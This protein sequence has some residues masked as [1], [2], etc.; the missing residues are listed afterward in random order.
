LGAE[1][2]V[3]ATSALAC[4]GVFGLN[5]RVGNLVHSLSSDDAAERGICFAAGQTVVLQQADNTQR[6]LRGHRHSITCSALS[7]NRRWLVT[8]DQ[9]EECV[10]IVWDTHSGLPVRMYFA[11]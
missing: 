1:G 10:M 8:A 2:A 6:V 4:K 11:D 7:L 5:W 9:G 3:S